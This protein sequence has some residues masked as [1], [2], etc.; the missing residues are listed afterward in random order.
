MIKQSL[1]CGLFLFFCLTASVALKVKCS[2]GLYDLCLCFHLLEALELCFFPV[3]VCEI[4]VCKH[5]ETFDT[6]HFT[7]PRRQDAHA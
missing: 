3:F 4:C 6:D 2:V 1:L 5:Q 7:S